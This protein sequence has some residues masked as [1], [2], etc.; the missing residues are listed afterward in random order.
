MQMKI[1]DLDHH[2]GGMFG[3]AAWNALI[4]SVLASRAIVVVC[5]PLAA[6]T[7]LL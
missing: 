5:G 7:G 3:S 4:L 6:P 2:S 1:P